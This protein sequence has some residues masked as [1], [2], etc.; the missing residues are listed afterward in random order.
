MYWKMF[1]TPVIGA[2]IGYVTN[3]IAVKMLFRPRTEIRIGGWKLPFTPGVIPK[4]QGRL[5]RAVGRAVEEQLLTKEILEEVLLSEDK[6]RAVEQSV[7]DWLEQA[8]TSDRTL[9]AS[10]SKLLSEEAVDDVIQTVE[11]EIT[12][13]VYGK[14]LE[15][16]PGKLVADKALESVKEKLADSFFGM[17]LGDSVLEPIAAQVGEKINEYVEEHGRPMVEQLVLEESDKLQQLTVGQTISAL[18]QYEM[19]VPA[20]VRTQYEK[21][22]REKLPLV[23]EKLN[24]SGIVEKRINAMDVLEVEELMLSIMKKELGAIVNLGALIGLLLGLVNAFILVL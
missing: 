4:G 2:V 15:L 5:A 3:W 22:V 17:M 18:T 9:K 6:C 13:A 24:L 20:M 23:L 1:L 16:D 21:L 8:K 10:V 14:I 12:E 11:E 7:S 19:D